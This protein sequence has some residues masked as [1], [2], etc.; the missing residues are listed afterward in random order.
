MTSDPTGP[1]RQPAAGVLAVVGYSVARVLLFLLVVAALSLLGV[2]G[3]PLVAVAILVSG[4]LSY[5]VLRPQRA[6]MARFVE[7]RVERRR[8]GR[9]ARRADEDDQQPLD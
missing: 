9:D 2:H 6:A 8:A 3:L 5:V 7:D 1:G 4:A